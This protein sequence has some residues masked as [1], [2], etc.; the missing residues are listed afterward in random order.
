MDG[1]QLS[2][3]PAL[4]P[5][6]PGEEEEGDQVD[7]VEDQEDDQQGGRQRFELCLLWYTGP[8]EDF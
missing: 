5:E 1:H 7:E 4:V 8:K 6:L 3:P 2:D